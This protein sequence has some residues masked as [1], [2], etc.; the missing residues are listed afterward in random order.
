MSNKKLVYIIL[1]TR[2]E[3]IKLAPVIQV[4]Q[5]CPGVET[6]VIL[7]GQH[8]E[9]VQQ[10]MQLFNLD[11]DR[12]LEIMQHRQ[13][14]SDITCRSLQGLEKLFEDHH[15]AILLEW[16]SVRV[17]WWSHK[18]KG[19]HMNDFICAAKTDQLKSG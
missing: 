10:V 9:M 14:L 8:R 18:I 2:P 13:S 12:N 15:P 7:T 6:Q 16:G 19:L 3:A 5:D 11:S 17:T 4:F 1:G